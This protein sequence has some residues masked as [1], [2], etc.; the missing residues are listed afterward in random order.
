MKPNQNIF[1]GFWRKIDSF[2]F[3]SAFAEKVLAFQHSFLHP[4]PP[5]VF[6]RPLIRYLS[7]GHISDQ[8]KRSNYMT[9]TV[10]LACNMSTLETETGE[11]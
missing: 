8:A 11:F 3:P 9:D 1:V 10:V 2:F 7:D 4:T 6:N 5:T